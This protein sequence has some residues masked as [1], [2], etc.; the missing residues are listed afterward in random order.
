LIAEW[1]QAANFEGLI[2]CG[3]VHWR[4]RVQRCGRAPVLNVDGAVVT[5]VPAF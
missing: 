3:H 1:I 4:E 5:L 2:V